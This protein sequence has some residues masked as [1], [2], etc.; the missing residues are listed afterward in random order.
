MWKISDV[1]REGLEAFKSNYWKSVLV[2]L[3]AVIVSGR[4]GASVSAS[5]SQIVNIIGTKDTGSDPG[6]TMAI[7]MF[8][9][10][11]LV[12]MSIVF[13]V[14]YV[15]KIFLLNPLKIG[16]CSFYYNNV[17]SYGELKDLGEAFDSGFYKNYVLTMF[18]KDLY[19]GL[20]SLL[21]IIPGIIKTFQYYMVPYILVD[22]PEYTHREAL[23]ASRDM[24]R[25]HKFHV[26]L[27]ELSFIGWG[28]LS[29]FTFNLLNIF[30]VTPYRETTIA[31]L[32][33]TLSRDVY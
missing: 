25:G 5:L 2:G 31:S 24:M 14:T 12:I 23:E 6:Y 15:I 3:V 27:L 18:L 26:F 28:I 32:Y 19:I 16:V 13:V 10:S 4:A 20:W 1:K 30:F 21:F 8:M 17:D 11:L 33:D 22:H 7:L 29:L 9:V